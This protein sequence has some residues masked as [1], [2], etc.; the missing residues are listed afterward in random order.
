MQGSL[1]VLG[2]CYSSPSLF[3]IA[4]LN[5]SIQDSRNN[6]YLCSVVVVL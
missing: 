2:F 4:D 3:A 1:L 6:T 5:Q